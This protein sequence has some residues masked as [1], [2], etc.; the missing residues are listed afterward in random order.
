MNVSERTSLHLEELGSP[1]R[2][3]VARRSA[4][5]MTVVQELP[6]LRLSSG[7]RDAEG[8]RASI[9]WVSVDIDGDTPSLVMELSYLRPEREDPTCPS[10]GS[11]DPKPDK[12][13]RDETVPFEIQRATVSREVVV[14][15]PVSRRHRTFDEHVREAWEELR[16]DLGRLLRSLA[17]RLSP[18]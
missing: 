18:A 8:R 13:R 12:R 11:I 15:P 14:G 5:G 4:E 16:R 6:F 1:V 9:D 2:T 3:R 10:L 7:V 17:Q